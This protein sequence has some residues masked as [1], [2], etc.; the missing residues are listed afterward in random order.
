MATYV[1]RCPGCSVFEVVQPMSALRPTHTCPTCGAP[2]ARVF[3]APGLLSTPSPVH[4]ALDRAAASAEAPQVVRSLPHGAPPPRR[5]RWNPVTGAAPLDAAHRP[6]GPHP[7]L[8]R[9]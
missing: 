1:F 5:R 8:P 6:A 7:P 4:R 3:T 9:W 2:A